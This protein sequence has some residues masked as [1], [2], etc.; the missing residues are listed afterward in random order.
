MRTLD[1]V[2]LRLRPF[3]PA[4]VDDLAALHGDPAVMRYIDDGRPVPREVVAEETLPGYLRAYTRLPDG[5]GHRAI[6]TREGGGR[7]VGWV[8]LLPPSSL[9]LED[10]RGLELGYRLRRDAWGHGYATEAARAVTDL[11]FGQ[12]GAERVVATT[13]TVNAG[14][15]RVM[16]KI[17]MRHAGTFFAD[18]PD[19]IE[20]AEHGDVVYELTAHRAVPC[21]GRRR[22]VPGG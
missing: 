10:A 14:S 15:R 17:G 21:S 19:Y 5:L 18:W 8:S 6:V 4:D 3:A 16:E 13:M 9:G 22:A 1:T 2:R 7:F 11:A 12:L 20:G